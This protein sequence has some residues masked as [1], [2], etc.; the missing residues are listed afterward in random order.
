MGLL[1]LLDSL[2]LFLVDLKDKCVFAQTSP[3]TLPYIIFSCSNLSL[4]AVV[5]VLFP[6]ARSVSYFAWI[7]H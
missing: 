5:V 3:A 1:I 7:A 2:L 6:R 4:L